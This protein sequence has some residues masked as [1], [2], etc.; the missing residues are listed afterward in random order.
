MD[1]CKDYLLCR[2]FELALRLVEPAYQR[3]YTQREFHRML[4]SAQFEEVL[5]LCRQPVI[6]WPDAPPGL[7]GLRFIQVAAI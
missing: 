6:G 4:A 2:L 1:W 7:F 3:C 5:Q